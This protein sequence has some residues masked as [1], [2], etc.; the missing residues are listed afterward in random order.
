VGDIVEMGD[1]SGE[2]SRIGIRASVV[3]TGR[4]A[5]IIVPNAQL[6]TERVTNWT[7]S[8]RRRR[9]DVP[10]GV[11][12]GTAPEKVVELLVAVARGHPLVLKEPPP[13]AF[14]MRFADSSINFELQAWTNQFELSGKIQ[15]ELAAAVYAALRG[16]GMTFPFPQRE[17]RVLSD[18]AAAIRKPAGTEGAT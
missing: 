6:I 15:T 7:L 18:S 11:D 3:R 4:G 2:V 1:L 13:Q 10:V 12:Y 9:I 5:E 17:I 16:A 14:F 8:D